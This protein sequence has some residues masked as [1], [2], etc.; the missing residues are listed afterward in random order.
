MYIFIIKIKGAWNFKQAFATAAYKFCIVNAITMAE[1]KAWKENNF[2]NIDVTALWYIDAIQK[3]RE[4]LADFIA[5]LNGER[6]NELLFSI[7]VK[8]TEGDIVEH[9]WLTPTSYSNNSFLAIVDN[10]PFNLK[11]ICYKDMVSVAASDVEDWILYEP[12]KK[13]Y[14]NFIARALK[15]QNK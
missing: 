9:I 5:V 11:N 2:V 10:T 1:E 15:A 12:R 3:A 6:A 8:F 14:G 7:K 13:M 4:Q